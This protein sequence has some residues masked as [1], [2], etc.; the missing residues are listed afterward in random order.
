[1]SLVRAGGN[2]KGRYTNGPAGHCHAQTRDRYAHT[3]LWSPSPWWELYAHSGAS[4]AGRSRTHEPSLSHSRAR[5]GCFPGT[6][7]PACRHNRST[8]L[9][10]TSQ[11]S[12]RSSAVIL[13]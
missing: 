5:F 11:P 3:S 2:G 9:W 1:M 6:F 4:H 13:R 8:R 7:S 12:I 10:F